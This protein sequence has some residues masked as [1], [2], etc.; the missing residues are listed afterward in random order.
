MTDIVERAKSA[1]EG[2]TEGSW[3][4]V[5]ETPDD[6]GGGE[7]YAYAIHGPADHSTLDCDWLGDEYKQQYGHEITEIVGLSDADAE[8][9]AQ[10]RTLVPELV[11]AIERARNS[12]RARYDRVEDLM[13][14][15]KTPAETSRHANEMAGLKFALNALD[16]ADD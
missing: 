12:I 16:P 3:S 13:L 9:I 1:L 15:A 7:P 14:A 5:Y 4:V 6:I 2:T 8:F 11:E 10:A